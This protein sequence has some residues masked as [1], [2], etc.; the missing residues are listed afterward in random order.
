MDFYKARTTLKSVRPFL[1][2]KISL[3]I[4]R[5]MGTWS[6]RQKGFTKYFLQLYAYCTFSFMLGGFF[7]VETVNVIINWGDMEKIASGAPLLLTNLAHAYKVQF[8][9]QIWIDLI[10]YKL[11]FLFSHFPLL[12]K[13]IYFQVFYR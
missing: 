3:N 12:M 9:P 6:P 13:M 2:L 11:N 1:L 4:L 8:I 5:W 10:N 7:V